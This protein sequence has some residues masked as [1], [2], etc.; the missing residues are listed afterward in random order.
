MPKAY[1][2]D[3]RLS[4]V[5]FVE[6]GH[7]CR[8]A[9]TVFGVSPSFVIILMRR[10]RL[11][12][13]VKAKAQGGAR[14]D[15]LSRHLAK[16]VAW[17]DADPSMTLAEMV[18][19]LASRHSVSATQSGLSKLLRRSGYTYKKIHV[20]KRGCAWQAPPTSS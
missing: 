12:N 20:G 19:R 4:V 18:D 2:E 16:L 13:S 6:R 11:T 9:A 17:L 1:S 5:R 10:Y 7:S 15:G 8:H 3:F 14:R